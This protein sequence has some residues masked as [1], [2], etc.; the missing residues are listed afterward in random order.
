MRIEPVKK[1]EDEVSV[2]REEVPIEWLGLKA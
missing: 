2:G 1:K